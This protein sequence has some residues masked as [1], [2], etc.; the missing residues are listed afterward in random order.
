MNQIW[1]WIM[2]LNAKAFCSV[3]TLLFFCT[4]GYCTFMYLTPLAP[5]K[6]GSG[7]LPA[8]PKPQEIPILDYV[9]RQLAGDDLSIPIEPFRPTMD[10]LYK[11]PGALDRLLNP[12]A[13][14]GGPG[15]PGGG[16]PGRGGPGGG[17]GPGSGKGAGTGPTGPTIITPKI[18]FNGYLKR[19]DG[20]SV[21]MFSDSSNGSKFFYE[22]GKTVHGLEILSTDMKEATVK[23]VDGSIG[24]IP[25]GG[26]VELAPEE[27]TT[28]IATLPV[29]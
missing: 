1:K 14:R 13:P 16:G 7:E 23:F 15:G 27:V 29:L 8:S 12:N 21:A 3:A 25:V 17:G 20:T 9:A 5:I 4:V 26:S 10:D 22:D 6:V 2:H 18:T 19:P 28:D 24:K 11:T